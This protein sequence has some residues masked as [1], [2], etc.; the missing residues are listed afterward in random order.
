[1]KT[2]LIY[3]LPLSLLFISSCC[4]ESEDYQPLDQELIK[5]FPHKKND[6]LHYINELNL[7]RDTIIVTDRSLY[8]SVSNKERC[9]SDLVDI[10][11]TSIKHLEDS[12]QKMTFTFKTSDMRL[13]L[14]G[15]YLDWNHKYYNVQATSGLTAD[16]HKELY[17]NGKLYDR[18]LTIEVHNPQNFFKKIFL[19]FDYGIIRYEKTDGTIYKIL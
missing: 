17:L 11:S 6:T 19:V 9:E 3:L 5:W 15:G 2:L 14:P 10:L 1:M 8:D 4:K 13:S 7:E 12:T 18:V 16:Y